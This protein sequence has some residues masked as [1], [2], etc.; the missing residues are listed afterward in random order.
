MPKETFK[1]TN[2]EITVIWK[3]HVCIHSKKCW[4]NLRAVFDPFVKPWIN[5]QG[6]T[7]EQIITQVNQCP[8]GA[9]SIENNQEHS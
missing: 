9:L 3:P 7:T 2:G 5:M 8:S 1:Y 6:A 4:T